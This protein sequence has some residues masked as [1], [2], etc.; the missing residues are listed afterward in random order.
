M[1]NSF[2]SFMNQLIDYAG[3]FP[4]A[5]LPLEEALSNYLAYTQSD[6][7]WM[8]SRFIIPAQ[9]LQDLS[10]LLGNQA[11]RLSVLGQAGQNSADFYE[12]L[13][14]DLAKLQIFRLKHPQAEANFFEVRLPVGEVT[15]ELLERVKPLLGAG[16]S[17]FYELPVTELASLPIL[18]TYQA[19]H[20]FV[21]V[22]L[23]CGGEVPAAFPSV[24]AIAAFIVACR[25]NG[26]ALKATAGLHHPLRHFN[27]SLQCY[28]HGFL[29]LFGAGLLAEVHK[30]D[31][32]TLV[33]ILADENPEHFV[34]SDDYFA[35]KD[36]Q[37]SAADIETYRQKML[38]S[39][40]SCSFDEPRDDL[41]ALNLLERIA[42]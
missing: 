41:A 38:I 34:F 2:R 29:N 1:Q 24:E 7:A 23:R 37:I 15:E 39:Y 22:K 42:K 30:L 20:G 25:D 18:A 14:V 6:D 5:K 35:W 31:I 19:K 9:Q 27:T 8:L 16:M 12:N 33:S 10:N 11:I 4:P 40:G 32:D 28:M 21:G 3:L 17:V 13:L 26:L 36:L